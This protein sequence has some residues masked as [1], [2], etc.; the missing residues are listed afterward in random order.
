MTAALWWNRVTRDY[1][2]GEGVRE[3]DIWVEPGEFFVL[4]GPSGSGKSTLLKIGSG[5][6]IPDSGTVWL[7]DRNVTRVPAEQRSTAMVFQNHALW[8]HMTVAD[9]V[10]FGLRV[11]HRPR[12]ERRAR[13]RELLR[14]VRLEGMEERRPRQLSG[15]QRQRVA[16]AR[17]LAVEPDVLLLDEPLSA[18][19]ARL[20]ED[21]RGELRDLQS[22]LG[23]AMVYVTHDQE[24]ALA[25]ADR[26]GVLNDGR[27]VQVGTPED[28][29]ER[30]AN[31]FVA[32]FC[33]KTVLLP[34]ARVEN[35]NRSA[36]AHIG[37]GCALQVAGGDPCATQIAV[38]AEAV[39]ISSTPAKNS[40]AA[41]VA[42]T[43][44]VDG[45]VAV[46]LATPVG[47]ITVETTLPGPHVG[48]RCFVVF[49]VGRTWLVA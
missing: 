20:R 5:F 19:D 34:I 32:R 41:T 30:P 26:V 44:Y 39:S 47:P 25:L 28:V 3:V 4:L 8:P 38:R 31:A 36:V 40:I 2:S 17:A 22:R 11:R 37:D 27:L 6:E 21:L 46:R 10:T 7:G 18:L 1:G 45:R 48:D 13:L 24:D 12:D 29:Y 15:G 23:V 33:G 35:G 9:N 42:D 43:R 14:L 49:P 16:L